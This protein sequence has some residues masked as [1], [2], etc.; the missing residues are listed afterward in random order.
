MSFNFSFLSFMLLQ[1]SFLTF[2]KVHLTK[3]TIKISHKKNLIFWVLKNSP[4]TLS[5][6]RGKMTAFNFTTKVL[7]SILALSKQK[8]R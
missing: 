3:W 1:P 8:M 7:N 6:L 4:W 2:F 5:L